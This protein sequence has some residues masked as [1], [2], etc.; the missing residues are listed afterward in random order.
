MWDCRVEFSGQNATKQC[1]LLC[2]I[3]AF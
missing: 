2:G 3:F 1:N